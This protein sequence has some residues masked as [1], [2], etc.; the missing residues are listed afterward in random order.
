MPT[1]TGAHCADGSRSASRC[2]GGTKASFERCSRRSPQSGALA[3]AAKSGGAILLTFD[4]A[5]A[6]VD[7]TYP[8]DVRVGSLLLL[9]LLERGPEYAFGT[10][11]D[12][13]EARVVDVL[14]RSSNAACSPAH[15]RRGAGAPP[16]TTSPPPRALVLAKVV[17]SASA[18]GQSPAVSWAGSSSAARALF[19]APVQGAQIGTSRA[20]AAG[21]CPT[22][23]SNRSHRRRDAWSPARQASSVPRTI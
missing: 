9:A 23:S 3:A 10:A 1:T 22:F 11:Y 4:D 7:R 6:D 5:L 21:C 16:A 2:T 18:S 15:H 17:T 8:F 14:A 19:C 12:L 20:R 13:T